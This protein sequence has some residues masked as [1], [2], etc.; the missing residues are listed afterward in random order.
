MI[1][2]AAL[3]APALSVDVA[4]EDD[5]WGDPQAWEALAAS[6]LEQAAAAVPGGVPEGAEVSLL[7]TGDA[8]VRSLNM[9]FRGR[10]TPTNVL[11]FPAAGLPGGAGFLGDIVMARETVAR[12]ANEQGLTIHAHV[13]HLLVHGFLH[14]LGYDH[15]DD[16]AARQ[17]ESLETAILA[18][19]G[20]ADPYRS[21]GRP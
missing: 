17:M 19:R 7:F 3:H 5:A 11:S 8:R 2:E 4:L 21:D 6:V 10:D 14:L 16:T 15:G 12:E 18:A 20:I 1:A 9:R 13:T